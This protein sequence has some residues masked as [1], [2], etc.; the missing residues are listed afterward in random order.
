MAGVV[1]AKRGLNIYKGD[2]IMKLAGKVAIVTGS[3]R[4]I[5]E[6]I[7]KKLASEGAS[8]VVTDVNIEGAR[9][10][11]DEIKA[12]GGAALA[13]KTDVANKAEVQDLVK[14]TLGKFKA[15]H[16]L[17]N[18]AA[19]VRNAPLIEMT[20]EAWDV[21]LDVDLKGVFFCTQAVM[22]HMIEQRYG[23]IVNIAS[24][25]GTGSS[26]TEDFANYAAAKGGVV[27][28]TKVAARV[29]GPYGINVNSI[30]PGVIMTEI[31]KGMLGTQQEVD[32]FVEGR[33]KLTVLGRTGE[34]NDI[35]NLALFL[36]SEDSSFITGQVICCDGGR[37]DRM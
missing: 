19:I 10:V 11:A 24:A 30:A 25:Q 27:Q 26:G 23:K 37:T 28:L 14:R 36:V 1:P 21:V 17:V 4:G 6:A 2:R 15:V 16:I 33:K 22:G 7:A 34:P 13:I 12:K 29:G 5:G 20:E 35:A 3:A 31:L 18:D 9:R 32:R 8:V